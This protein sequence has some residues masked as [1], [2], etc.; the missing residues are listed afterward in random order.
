MNSLSTFLHIVTQDLT[1]LE[2]PLLLISLYSWL[3]NWFLAPGRFHR[4]HTNPNLLLHMDSYFYH[5]LPL[6]MRCHIMILLLFPLLLQLFYSYS[7][8]F[9]INTI[10]IS[11][12]VPKHA[13]LFKTVNL[14]HQLLNSW[15]PT[16]ASD[17]WICLSISSPRESALPISTGKS[18]HIN[19]FLYH[20]YRGKS[21]FL[22][23]MHY[24]YSIDQI[25]NPDK[26]LTSL[27]L[28]L[29]P[30]HKGPTI[31]GP[32]PLIIIYNSLLSVCP[33]KTL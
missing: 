17:C 20:T 22:L 26:I 16:L 32:P 27:L 6:D 9:H 11:Q 21:L 23:Y 1:F 24:L 31:G 12:P 10:P 30:T 33:D 8:F 3:Y 29:T 7:L 18:T 2:T 28:D 4:V 14:T 25:H 13:Y 5:S 15:N 19:T